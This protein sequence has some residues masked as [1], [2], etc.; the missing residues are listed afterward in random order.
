[1]KNDEV[2]EILKEVCRE[3]LKEDG[4]IGC[5]AGELS[6][7]LAMRR[8]NVVRELSKLINQGRIKK[9][10]GRPVIYY[11]AEEG[12]LIAGIKDNSYRKDEEDDPFLRLTGKQ[13][14]LKHQISLAKAAIVYPPKGLHTLIVGETGVGKSFFAKV[15]FQFALASNRIKDKNSFAVFNC[16]DYANNPQLLIA[17]LFGVKK[18]AYT[19]AYEDKEGIIEKSRDGILFLDEIHRLPPEG[20]ELLFT[21]IDYGYYIPLGST[22]EIPISLMIICATTENTE[23]SLLKTFKRRIPVTIT[24]PPLRDRSG[25]ERLDLIKNFLQEESVRVH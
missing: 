18:G 9:R 7:L 16:A 10:E 15:M 25:D 11:I 19:G 1:M 20:Q 12:E 23:S 4:V 22:K 5:S 2:F 8:P 14:S 21:L 3:Q 13:G 17:H 6:D 24:L